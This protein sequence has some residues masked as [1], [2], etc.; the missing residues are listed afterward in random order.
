MA[1]QTISE[2][3]QKV[4][5]ML[6]RK[7]RNIRLPVDLQLKLFDTLI[8]PAQLYGC[9]I[10]GFGNYNIFEKTQLQFCKHILK[11]RSSTPNYMICGELG[12]IP[13]DI[14]IKLRMACF[15]NKLIQN[16]SKLSVIM[17]KVM[18]FLSNTKN[19]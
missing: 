15:W 4:L 16:T 13:V 14:T 3:T 11:L 5:F 8:F 2:Q 6:Y 17:Y 9:E 1:K 19:S 18:L 12:R 7:L 10:W